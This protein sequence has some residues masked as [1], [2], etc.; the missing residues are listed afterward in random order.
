MLKVMLVSAVLVSVEA[1]HV[2]R[3]LLSLQRRL[4]PTMD[5]QALGP[6][7]Q[8]HQYPLW[9]HMMQH[10][11]C[12]TF[13]SNVE[14][15]ADALSGGPPEASMLEN[16]VNYL[17]SDSE[18]V[19]SIVSAHMTGCL[20]ALS[21]DLLAFVTDSV[22]CFNPSIV[23]TGY[24]KQELIQLLDSLLLGLC[25][26]DSS[27]YHI[28][29]G[30][31]MLDELFRDVRPDFDSPT[32]VNELLPVALNMINDCDAILGCCG[33]YYKQFGQALELLSLARF[34]SFVP[35]VSSFLAHSH[36]ALP[37]SRSCGRDR[38][39]P[40]FDPDAIDYPA[41]P[42]PEEPTVP[43]FAESQPQ[44]I[45]LALA[46]RHTA[47]GVSDGMAVMFSTLTHADSSSVEFGTAAGQLTSTVE[48]R[49]SSYND[50]VGSVADI[51]VTPTFNHVA[52]LTDLAPNTQ[53]FYQ[54]VH[55]NQRSEVLS[56]TSAPVTD[57]RTKVAI[58]GDM[59]LYESQ[60]TMDLLENVHSDVDLYFH[61]GD[62]SYADNW[63]LHNL[64]TFGYETV[65]NTFMNVIQRLAA[66]KPY[67][68][69]PGN[70]E[71]ECHEAFTCLKN[72]KLKEA[73]VNY[74]AFNHRFHMP[75]ASSGGAAN[76][77]YSFNHGLVHFV[78]IDTETDFDGAPN[79]NFTG[80]PVGG[81]GDQVAWLERDLKTAQ[82]NREQQPWII[83]LGHRP[84]YTV[85]DGDGGRRKMAKI[86][87]S[88]LEPLFDKYE[89]NMYF[90]GHQH[91]YERTLPMFQNQPDRMTA[92][93][94]L[95]Q[96]NDPKHTTYVVHGS[97]GNEELHGEDLQEVPDWSV[98]QDFRHFGI[99][100]MTVHNRTH[101]ALEHMLSDSG[102]VTDAV[103]LKIT[104][105]KGRSPPPDTDE[106]DSSAQQR[107]RAAGFILFS[108]LVAA[109]LST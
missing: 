3:H 62:I 61:I 108:L 75:S 29:C 81:F 44:Q 7:L 27:R 65:W 101:L 2:G 57:S 92:G 80:L 59:G 105:G 97:A 102:E 82:A 66:T 88:W 72:Q 85:S 36:C 26:V 39:M 91:H 52:Q 78:S 16:L 106:D 48:C 4:A 100:L 18:E 38:F 15:I 51:T 35:L 77:W 104:T 103:L 23:P 76:M 49:T 70:H 24:G 96:Y 22:T 86:L 41:E 40:T 109:T 68:V 8:K 87:Q 21:D 54:C 53:Y 19:C 13:I 90:S 63:L 50:Q 9:R 11:K 83:V 74:T 67:M 37:G 69:L 42:M 14:G 55:G 60:R 94:T 6:C 33:Q 28:R 10:P 1:S 93:S 107:V 46:G 58:F 95:Q 34:N 17:I 20:Y 5:M 47:T 79:N 98:N 30:R 99:T 56:F 71:T 32:L 89:V 45:H 31:V 43:S 73:F 64:V 25:A 84:I 12:S